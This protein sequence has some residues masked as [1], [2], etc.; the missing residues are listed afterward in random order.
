MPDLERDPVL[1]LYSQAWLERMHDGPLKETLNDPALVLRV[2]GL[3]AT[4]MQLTLAENGLD[5]EIVS[6]TPIETS[7]GTRVLTFSLT[8]KD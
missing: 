8:A 7:E 5:T 1:K 6:R 2:V 3:L 4:S